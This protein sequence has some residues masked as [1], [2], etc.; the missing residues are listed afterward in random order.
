MLL[1]AALRNAVSPSYR[2]LRDDGATGCLGEFQD[3]LRRPSRSSS[4][5]LAL[6]ASRATPFPS[7]TR[8]RASQ[9]CRSSGIQHIPQAVT[10]EIDP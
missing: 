1:Q 10:E 7:G 9:A 2:S 6:T 3:E 8:L 5:S 4:Q